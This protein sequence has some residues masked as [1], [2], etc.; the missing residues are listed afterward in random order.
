MLGTGRDV[1]MDVTQAR[2]VIL[3]SANELLTFH[4][5]RCEHV[6]KLYPGSIQDGRGLG[7]SSRQR[8]R[9]M[10]DWHLD[11][12]ANSWSQYPIIIFSIISCRHG[13]MLTMVT[14]HC[15][16]PKRNWK[17][18]GR[19]VCLMIRTHHAQVLTKATKT[20]TMKLTW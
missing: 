6:H 18:T 13:Q 7:L 19:Y 8:G 17:R 20:G 1:G 4:C 15:Q 10:P 14:S 2:Y 5:A 16:I 3:Y 12:Y 11:M 9:R